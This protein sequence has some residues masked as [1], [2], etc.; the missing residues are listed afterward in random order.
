MRKLT[1]DWISKR[2][3]NEKIGTPLS[4]SSTRPSPPSASNTAYFVSAIIWA[5]YGEIPSK[6]LTPI[7]I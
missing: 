6:L 5:E 3:T 4:C 2:S 1:P 7:P